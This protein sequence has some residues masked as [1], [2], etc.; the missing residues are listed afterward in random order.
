[1]R[2]NPLVKLPQLLLIIGKEKKV[3]RVA[4][5]RTVTRLVRNLVVHAIQIKIP[6]KLTRQ[7]PDRKTGFPGLARVRRMALNDHPAEFEDSRTS[8]PLRKLL[9]KNL[10]IQAWK[11]S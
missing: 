4:Q 10:M 5:I 6:P 2:D 8:H 3:I 1:M 9:K 7:I 11:K